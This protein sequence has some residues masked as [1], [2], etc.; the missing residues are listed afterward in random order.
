MA[1]EVAQVGSPCDESSHGLFSAKA[2]K[3]YYWMLQLVNRNRPLKFVKE[4]ES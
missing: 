4:A 2:K 3:T 1:D